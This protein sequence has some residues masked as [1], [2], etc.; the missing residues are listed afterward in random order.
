MY[1]TMF[2]NLL[3][4]ENQKNLKRYLLWVEL[5]LLVVFVILVFTFLYV[6]IQ[7][8]PDGVTITDA[9]L[10]KIPQL[11]SWPGSLAFS[12][13]FAAG[14]KL[15]LIIF[16]GAA[17]ASEYA[18]RTYQLW[19]SRGVPR[20]LLLAAK[21]ISFCLPILLVVTGALIA[22]GL[23]T[24]IFSIHINGTLHLEQVNFWQLGLDIFRTAYTL[25]PYVGITFLL[26]IA[27]RSAVA[28]I[29]GCTAYGL[30]AESFLD[31][32]LVLLPG[33]F[34][35]IAKY[36]PA[37][38]MQSVLSASW[39]SSALMDEVLSGLVT[40]NQAAIGIAA[41]TLS[42]FAAS[43]WLFKRQDFSG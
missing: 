14:S 43:L 23:I 1:W 34:G 17:T 40:P 26:A 16:V 29:G 11:I 42:L 5:I 15:L 41:W 39:T 37:N 18:W 27:T 7:G 32:I 8:M 35:E 2:R 24:M 3:W 28:A 36:L 30:I 31:Q 38:L 33:R 13:R 20:T 4:I 9:D 19:L 12:L 25:L 22:G 6:A 10:A 21:F